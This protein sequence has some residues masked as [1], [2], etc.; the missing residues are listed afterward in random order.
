[1][2]DETDI[3]T[4]NTMRE[5]SGES[6]IKLW[7]LLRANRL[8]VSSVLTSAVFVA[9][10]IAVAVL[11]P[12]FSRQI[13]SG[14]MIET[15]F[16]T[17]ITVIVTGT[18]LVVTIGQL[19]LSQEN[20]PLGDQRER[21]ASSMDVRDFTEELIGSPSPADPS[22]FLRQIIGITAQRTTAL[23]ESIDKND[24]ENLRE[25]VDEFADSVTGNAD[26]VRDQLEDAQFGSFDVLFAA[27]NFNY[28]WKIFQVE[29][30]SNEYEQSL[31]EEERG[32][33]DDLKTAL[34]LFGPAREHIKTLYFQWALIDLSQMILYAAVPALAVAGIM[35]GIVD[36][37]T[38]P[39]STLGFDHIILVVGGA[40]AVT[41]VPFMLFVSYVLRVVTIAKRTLAIEPLILRESQ[42]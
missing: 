32:L 3:S 2:T 9:F 27:L 17:M 40:F 13:E 37:G 16:S 15:M 21:M 24:N 18:T 30:L 6:R 39:G 7:L 12:P 23:R 26:L 34:S 25:E 28:S 4:A 33:L 41:L 19:V 10:V 5:R 20:G 1:M 36:A 8:L 31:T 11:H 35:V 42:R 14:D 29:R 22:E 38:F